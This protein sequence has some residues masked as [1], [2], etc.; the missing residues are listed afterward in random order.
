[1]ASLI[2]S[3]RFRSMV[4]ERASAISPK[5]PRTPEVAAAHEVCLLPNAEPTRAQRG[6]AVRQSFSEGGPVQPPRASSGLRPRDNH[7]PR[8]SGV[9]YV[10]LLISI[11]D[12]AAE[13]P[14]IP[15]NTADIQRRIRRPG[16]G[17]RP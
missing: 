2:R 15:D 3:R 16:N 7:N 6:Q 17:R 1:M 8:G 12:P 14:P 9:F 5:Y 4:I 11:A 13:L 10:Y